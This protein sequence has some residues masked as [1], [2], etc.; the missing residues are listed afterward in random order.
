MAPSTSAADAESIQHRV[1]GRMNMF[2]KAFR[3]AA[4]R[5]YASLPTRTKASIMST[6]AADVKAVS[7]R[8]L[9]GARRGLLERLAADAGYGGVVANG[10][11]GLFCGA[12]TDLGV[13]APDALSGTWASRT[14]RDITRFFEG[15]SGTYLDI[16]ADES[17]G[18]V[19]SG[20]GRWPVL[21]GCRG[22]KGPCWIHLG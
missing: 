22:A 10:E 12:I 19:L 2:R 7:Q 21:R 17:A 14:V 9:D 13:L 1:G 5:G 3:S 18:L 6:I 15:R 16:G 4:R 20:A 8:P 11:Y